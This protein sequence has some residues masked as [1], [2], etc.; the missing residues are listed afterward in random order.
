MAVERRSAAVV[1]VWFL[2]LTIAGRAVTMQIDRPPGNRESHLRPA[3][4]FEAAVINEGRCRSAT[5]RALVQS[6]QTSDLTVS[7]LMKRVPDRRVAGGLQFLGATPTDR[8]LRIVLTF[9][10]DRYQRIT[11]LGHELQHA[12]EV[13]GVPEIRSKQ[14]FDEFYRA[15]GIP[16]QVEG[17]FETEGARRTELRIQEEIAR[18]HSSTCADTKR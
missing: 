2:V 7:V 12:V 5:F 6:L 9:P 16:S 10:L 4:D 8:I 13:A 11:M 1:S 14:A 15:H 18:E 3:S 17:A